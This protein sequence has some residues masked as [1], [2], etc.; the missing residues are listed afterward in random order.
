MFSIL[1]E[2]VSV[3]YSCRLYAVHSI[4][5]EKIQC[6]YKRNQNEFQNIKMKSSVQNE[7]LSELNI[8]LIGKQKK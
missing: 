4:F 2:I 5:I 1:T 3:V 7:F 6:L 8:H